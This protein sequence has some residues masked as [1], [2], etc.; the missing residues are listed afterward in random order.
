MYKLTCIDRYALMCRRSVNDPLW[1]QVWIDQFLQYQ[2]LQVPW[3]IVLGNHDYEGNPQA[4]LDF[5][6][7]PN[8]PGGL[9]QAGG[10]V[11]DNNLNLPSSQY[12]FSRQLGPYLKV[13]FVAFDTNASQDYMRDLHPHL[14]KVSALSHHESSTML[15]MTDWLT[16]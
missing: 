12:T 15:T 6:L 11:I 10:D 1:K 5:T 4:Q 13:D 9:W 14:Y 7:H 2:S 16:V 3:K 8:N